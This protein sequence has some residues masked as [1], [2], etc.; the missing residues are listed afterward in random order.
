M[1]DHTTDYNAMSDEAFRALVK[2]F[3]EA[4]YPPELRFRLGQL[5]HEVTLP[6]YRKLSQRGWVAP[7]WLREHGGMGLDPAKRI[8]WN[9]V[10]DAHGCARFADNGV[11]M[12]GPLVIQ[13]GTPEQQARYLPGILSGDEVWCQG[14]SEPGSGSDLASLRTEAVWN[15]EGWTINGQKIWTSRANQAQWC[16]MLVRTDKNGPKPQD[17][18]SY[19]IVPLDAPGVTIRPIDTLLMVDDFCEIFFDN[20]KVPADALVGELH[21]GWSIVKVLMGGERMTL[22]ASMLARIGM[23][24]MR[25]LA[26]AVGSWGEPAF[27]DRYARLTAELA[28]HDS[29]YEAGLEKVRAGGDLSVEGAMLKVHMT[30]M[31]KRITT[32]MVELA[33]PYAGLAEPTQ[34][35]QDTDAAGTFLFSLAGTIYGGSSEVQRNIL[36]KQV[37]R[38]P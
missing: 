32:A 30:E 17:G 38:L 20:V 12:G 19:F 21:K 13:F 18:I 22:G 15:G 33:G 29:L 10:L 25:R 8:I 36:A 3:L 34:A 2:D 24:M 14:Y 28:D 11:M 1:T 27:M 6:W 23:D 4:N 16:H 37:L 31:Y 35:V 7:S 5:P 26:K 9:D